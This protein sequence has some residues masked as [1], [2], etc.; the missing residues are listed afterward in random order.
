MLNKVVIEENK[1]I[2]IIPI[3]ELKIGDIGEI[4]NHHSPHYNGVVLLRHYDRYISLSKPCDSWGLEADI[5]V[6]RI[7]NATVTLTFGT[8]SE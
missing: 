1:K 8:G 3:K 7:D 6:R 5:K 2:D 4:V